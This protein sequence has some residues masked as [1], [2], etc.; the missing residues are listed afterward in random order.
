MGCSQ[1]NLFVG[2]RGLLNYLRLRT[3]PW[4]YCQGFFV[5]LN[6]VQLLKHR[7]VIL[8]RNGNGVFAN[9]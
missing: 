1:F 8:P 7:F 4:Q 2:D 9:C 5:S 3:N 6:H